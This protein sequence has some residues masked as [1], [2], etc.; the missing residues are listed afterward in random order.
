VCFGLL[1]IL[2]FILPFI[3]LLFAISAIVSAF[4]QSE[5]K[6]TVYSMSG[7]VLGVIGIVLN[8][9]VYLLVVAYILLR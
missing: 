3:G 4:N 2:F 1:G 9:S 8:V 5:I 6:E 7:H